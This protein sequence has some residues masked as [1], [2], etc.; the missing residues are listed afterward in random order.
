M[1]DAGVIRARI[2]PVNSIRNTYPITV[3][4]AITD[5]SVGNILISS[6]II[7]A[8]PEP[9]MTAGDENNKIVISFNDSLAML[10][11]S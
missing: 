10:K 7:N 3:T 2:A 11:S 4:I 8:N 6:D 1:N 9:K 5:I